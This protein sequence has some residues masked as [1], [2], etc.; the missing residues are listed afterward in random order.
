MF[1]TMPNA[2]T[3]IPDPILLRLP[4]TLLLSFPSRL[5]LRFPVGNWGAGAASTVEERAQSATATKP[6]ERILAVV[7]VD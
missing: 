4:A 3:S 5:P 2:R 6:V 7:C 1:M